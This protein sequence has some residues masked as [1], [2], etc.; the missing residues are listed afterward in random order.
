MQQIRVSNS[1]HAPHTPEIEKAKGPKGL[2]PLGA[3]YLASNSELLIRELN[4]NY[5]GPRVSPQGIVQRRTGIDAAVEKRFLS[6]RLSIG[7]RVTDVFNR[8]GFEMVLIQ[9]GVRQESEFKW[10][11]RRFFIT[12]SYQF[13]NIDKKINIKSSSGGEAD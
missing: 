12:A 3:Q 7:M 13:G 2:W 8:K 11:T 6:K 5:A 4:V 10:L 9:E 1:M